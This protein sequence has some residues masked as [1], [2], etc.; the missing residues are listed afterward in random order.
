MVQCSAYTSHDE[1][2]QAVQ[3]LLASGVPGDGIR[4]LMGEPERDA[5]AEDMGAFAGAV[6]AGDPHGGF[7]GAREGTGSFAG[8]GAA[9]RGGSFADADREI[10]TSYPAGI[11]HQRVAGHHRVKQLLLDA[12]LDEATAARDVEALHMGRIL[13]LAQVHES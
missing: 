11:A 4:V 5:R 7:A 6:A 9:Q 13:V 12:G 3:A 1:A 2:S 8:D 10:E